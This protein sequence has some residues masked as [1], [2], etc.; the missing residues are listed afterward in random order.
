MSGGSGQVP[1]SAEHMLVLELNS[2]WR[3]AEDLRA[4]ARDDGDYWSAPR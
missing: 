2:N 4:R 3:G 1:I